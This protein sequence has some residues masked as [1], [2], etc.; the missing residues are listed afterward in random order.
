MSVEK[1]IKPKFNIN[2][3]LISVMAVI[4][5]AL[6]V[7]LVIF[8]P[9]SAE[10]KRLEEQLSLGNKYLSELNYEQAIV[11]Y[12]AVIEIDPKNVDA[13]L[14][15]TDAYIAQGE[16]DKA[17]EVLEKAMDEVDSNTAEIIKDKLEEVHKAREAVEVTPTVVP[18]A[19]STPI[20]MPEPTVTSTPTLTPE[21]TATSAPTPTTEPTA[22]STPMPTPKPTVTNTPIPTPKPVTTS[23]PT[24]DPTATSTPTPEPTV[25]PT[26]VAEGSIAITLKMTSD[27]FT[28]GTRNNRYV[29]TGFSDKGKTEFVTYNSTHKIKLEL[30]AVSDTGEVVEGFY[31]SNDS[32]YDLYSMLTQEAAYLEIVCPD[33][34][35]YYGI[36]VGMPRKTDN[37]KLI[38]VVFNEGMLT[39][40]QNALRGWLGLTEVIIPKSVVE[41]G[42]YAFYDC[43]NLSFNVVEVGGRSIGGRAF[44]N[45]RINTL[46]MSSDM[47]GT[48]VIGSF[49]KALIE[50]VVISE[51]VTKLPSTLF[52]SC[53]WLTEISLPSSI[54][55]IGDNVLRDCQGITELRI[56][57]SVTSLGGYM[58]Y[59]CENIKVI[60][61]PQET[62]IGF[63]ALENCPNLTIVTSS[64]S[65]AEQY[66]IEKGIPYQIQ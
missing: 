63:R 35:V 41:I 53:D 49:Q 31:S 10:A 43:N 44:G 13:Y 26:P 64:G 42:D 48:S 14:G 15:L 39:L 6:L 57:E 28:Y 37:R 20:L 16:Y 33:S 11:A 56:P 55:S 29:C 21:P 36:N 9:K 52:A 62:K 2:K 47:K 54:T 46:Q 25:T 24:P 60:Y 59:D 38:N 66:A 12:S 32:G 51:G 34:Y 22:T 17:I 8:V 7:T 5:I 23:I 40:D 19:T 58:F 18:T 61:I 3:K 1:N 65:Y 4:A 45:V 30:P 50:N 27:C